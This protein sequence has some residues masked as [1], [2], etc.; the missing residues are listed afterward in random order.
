MV[1]GVFARVFRSG[2]RPDRARP[3]AGP[4]DGRQPLGRRARP[5]R[6]C[7]TPSPSRLSQDDH[8]RFAEIGDSLARELCDAAREH[9]HDEGYVVPRA[10]SRS[11]SSPTR[12]PHTGTF[13]HRRP[14]AGG[15]G[16]GRGRLAAAAQ[17]RAASSSAST[18][19]SVG[20]LP[21]CDIMLT[22]TNVSRRHAEIRPDARRL[23]PRRPRL[24][25]RH[26]GSTACGSPSASCAT[27]TSSPSATPA[28]PSRPPDPASGLP[29][30][31]RPRAPVI[32]S[33][34]C[35]SN[36]SSSSSC[37]CW[38]CSTSSSSGC[39]GPSGPSCD[40]PK[41]GRGRRRVPAGRRRPGAAGRKARQAQAD[42]GRRRPQLVVVE[43][44]D[45]RGPGLPARRRGDRRPGRRLPDHARRHL[46]LADP[47]PGVPA[48]R[49]V[50]RRGPRLDQ[51][52][53][54]QPAARW[55]GRWSCTPGDRLQI[56]N[57][58]MELA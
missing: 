51:R 29:R 22:D 23:R 50:P 8:D 49:P 53:L 3:P 1:E 39:C 10:R 48:R 54:P 47:R 57:T 12:R 33:S 32:C 56:G 6:S 14:H 45:Q 19:V 26:A 30:V 15:P 4:R 24:D 2:L 27:A 17:R 37:A 20:R 13:T 58:V 40:P 16:R 38:R 31:G 43:P 21:E 55:R 25:Q 7:P 5:H 18:A 34:P 46:R 28:S 11:S 9:A 44:A 35:P 52:H 36:S 42:R 41:L